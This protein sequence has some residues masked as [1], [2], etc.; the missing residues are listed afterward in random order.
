MAVD[1]KKRRGQHASPSSAGSPSAPGVL[2]A[3][4]G[5][6]RLGFGW[7]VPV[8]LPEQYWSQPGGRASTVSPTW[9]SVWRERRV[10]LF[11]MSGRHA[12]RDAQLAHGDAGQLLS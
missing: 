3:R 1:P 6:A 7:Y 12:G 8:T 9:C 11:E 2:T 5:R 10:G 4:R